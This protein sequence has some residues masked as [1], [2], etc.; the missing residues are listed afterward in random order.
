MVVGQ[1]LPPV[2]AQ[3]DITAH[4]THKE[5]FLGFPATGRTMHFESVGVMRVQNG[6]IT[7]HWGVGNLLSAVIQLGLFE[8]E[9]EVSR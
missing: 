8:P 4:G 9:S 7:N 3:G 2:L 5:L 6:K 1:S